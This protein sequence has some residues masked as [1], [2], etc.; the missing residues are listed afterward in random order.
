M[1]KRNKMY[2]IEELNDNKYLIREKIQGELVAEYIVTLNPK[3][4]SC[5]YF[6][7]SHNCHNH[8]HFPQF[9]YLSPLY[10]VLPKLAILNLR[11]LIKKYPRVISHEQ[12]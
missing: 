1:N 5:Q 3:T 12:T 9:Y 10:L 2:L 11:I 7:E 8:F 4:C 6:A